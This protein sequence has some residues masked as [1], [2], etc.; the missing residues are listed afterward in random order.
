MKKRYFAYIST[1]KIRHFYYSIL[2]HHVLEMY[3]FPVSYNRVIFMGMK[4]AVVQR[5]CAICEQRNI[6]LNQLANISGVTPSTIYSFMRSDRKD[7]GIVTLKK[8]CDGL[9]ISMEE[10]FNDLSFE[11]LGPEV[12]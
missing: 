1:E 8:L 7:I 6:A 2:R 10:F 11:N 12:K 4:E 5:I 3:L 9:E